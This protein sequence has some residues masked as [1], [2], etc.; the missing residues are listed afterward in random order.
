MLD[1]LPNDVLLLIL[2]QFSVRKH[3]SSR[4]HDSQFEVD[5]PHFQT[6]LAR[7]CRT[8]K[9]VKPA[10]EYY[11][12][13][14]YIKPRPNPRPR[15]RPNHHPNGTP[16][17]LFR[18]PEQSQRNLRHFLRTIVNRPD[19]ASHVRHL[20]IGGWKIAASSVRLTRRHPARGTITDLYMNAAHRV[21]LGDYKDEWITDLSHGLEPAEIGLLLTLTSNLHELEI[22]VPGDYPHYG[23]D[24]IFGE[25]FRKALEYPAVSDR[26][27][28]KN[29]RVIHPIFLD[30]LRN[31]NRGFPFYS[32]TDLFHLPGLDVFSADYPCD[33]R[34]IRVGKGHQLERQHANAVQPTS[35]VKSIQLIESTLC[36]TT[37][38]SLVSSCVHLKSFTLVND[39]ANPRVALTCPAVVAALESQTQNLTSL[40]LLGSALSL[41]FQNPTFAAFTSLRNLHIENLVDPHNG[42]PLSMPE[43]FAPSL[44]TLKVRQC[45]YTHLTSLEQLSAATKERF[46]NLKTVCIESFGV[47]MDRKTDVAQ[48]IH[49]IT[50]VFRKANVQF[51]ILDFVGCIFVPDLAA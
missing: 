1:R 7:L 28:L 14:A 26:P 2:D 18:S 22:G 34:Q 32:L 50:K 47:G 17:S 37:I 36:A 10:A 43:I 8:C 19:L 11:L 30:S 6:V 23:L 51:L 38:V 49:V 27:F 25:I 20:A 39:Y 3:D 46:P 33:E 4:M 35:S 42:S 5:V 48:R 31:G 15:I 12:Y 40:T 41:D 16:R 45:W 29:L 21:A 9:H 24:S 44:E 13:Q